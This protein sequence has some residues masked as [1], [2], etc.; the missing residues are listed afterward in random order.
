MANVAD[1]LDIQLYDNQTNKNNLNL[2]LREFNIDT[3]IAFLGCGI[4]SVIRGV[5]SN[6]ELYSGLCKIYGQSTT[7][8]GQIK[9]THF[10]NLFKK[11]T[12]K[13]E[14][15]SEIF[16]LVKPKGTSG[17]IVYTYIIQAFDCYVTTN[18][19]EPVEGNFNNIKNINNTGRKK[20]LEI[21]FFTF[22]TLLEKPV[23]YSLTYLHGH[24]KIGFCILRQKDYEYFYPS[25]YEKESGVYVV[26]NSLTNILTGWQSVFMGC[27]LEAN[28]KKFLTYLIDRI[29]MEN[30]SN[31]PQKEVKMHYWITDDSDINQFLKNAPVDKLDEFKQEYFDN[32]AKINIRP[33]IYKGDHQF[34]E[35]LC[36]NLSEIKRK[37]TSISEQPEASRI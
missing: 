7:N 5:P 12:K 10:S 34:I 17:P 15:D 27:S 37:E 30:S 31:K 28:L 9:P 18:Y 16:K 24:E 29:K 20:E 19:H 21:Y 11:C 23:R 33:I 14:F 4:N 13:E 36:Q 35:K 8:E 1:T 6:N 3:F 22:P 26:E 32:Y 25:L 2:L